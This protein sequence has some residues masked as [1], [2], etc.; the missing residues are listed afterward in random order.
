MKPM[1]IALLT[2]FGIDD[3]YAGIM[4]GIIKDI[5]PDAD[6]IDL[7]H[8]IPAGD[9]QRGAFVLWQ[10]ARDLPYGTVF[11][12]VVDPG[13]GTNR[14]A[15][16]LHRG[17]QIFIGPDNGLLSYLFYN[18]QYS[19]WELTNP[20]YQLPGSSNTFHGRDIFA[21][22]AA[23]AA[24]GIPGNQFGPV[25]KSL[26]R[27]ADPVFTREGNSFRGEIL[28]RDS[29][30]NLFTSLGILK[31]NNDIIEVNSWITG[32]SFIIPNI[33]NIM[34]HVNQ[35]QLPLVT[36]FGSVPGNKSAGLIGS[37]GLLEII[38]NQGS[39]VDVLSL[40]RGDPVTLSW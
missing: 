23:Y 32:E 20:K 22:G 8:K 16:F 15:I 24:Q 13:V 14:K 6:F 5:S 25:V 35:H 33:K 21:P 26:I 31:I 37:T 11:L 2:D 28:S 3:P 30:G 19:A 1:M 34:I 9:I 17:G 27:L 18:S 7:T 4:K 10:A 36:T 40:K 39:S 38:T 29:F 12:S